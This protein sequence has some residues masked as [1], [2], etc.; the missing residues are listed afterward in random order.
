MSMRI[1]PQNI[2]VPSDDPFKHDLLDRQTVVE[3][4]THIVGNIEGP[5]VLAVDAAWGFGKTTFLRMW[6][7]HLRNQGFSLVEFNAWETDFSEDPFLTLSTELTES[8]QSSKTKLPDKIINEFTKAS[9]EVLR[10]LVPGIIR[11][12]ASNIPVAGPHFAEDAAS[13]AEERISQ[14]TKARTSIK[15]FRK[16]FQDMATTLSQEN[17]NQPL[18]VAIDELDRCRPSY[19][20]ELLE[21]AKHLFSVDHVVFVMAINCEQLAHS[22]RALY[23]NDFDAEGYLRRFIDIDFQ[24]P[25]PSRD[26]FIQMQFQTT[27]IDDFFGHPPENPSEYYHIY[28]TKKSAREKSGEKLRAMLLGFFGASDLSLRTVGQA[29]HRLGLLYASLH[30]DEDDYG[31]ATTVALIL[32]TLDQNLYDRFVKGEATDLD[33]VDTIF[34]HPGLKP[35]QYEDW[36]TEFEVMIILAAQEL[37]NPNMPLPK[38]FYS[39]LKDRYSTWE[40]TA[41]E[42]P[43]DEVSKDRRMAGSK[44]AKRIVEDIEQ[45]TLWKR[46]LT[47]FAQAVQRLELLSTTLINDQ[48]APSAKNS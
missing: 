5:C 16:V 31:L 8:L 40:V 11:Y 17:T 13:F 28:L 38:T 30:S 23:G 3:T 1:Q 36:N 45:A 41:H 37:K 44:H 2:E 6:I 14:H 21:V 7:Q 22:V 26:T 18:V 4:L 34:E 48:P 47:G 43:E 9:K 10:W 32:R 20:V 33:V 46:E 15:Q 42:R 39:P 19:A 35:L 25:A 12:M 29:I 24:L 27:G